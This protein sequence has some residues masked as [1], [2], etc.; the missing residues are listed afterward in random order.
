[1]AN[2]LLEEWMSESIVSKSMMIL[3]ELSVLKPCK[4]DI[5]GLNLTGDVPYSRESKA[6]LG[7][8]VFLG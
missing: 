1:M 5:T 8:G 3:A 4:T 6:L 2:T 7:C